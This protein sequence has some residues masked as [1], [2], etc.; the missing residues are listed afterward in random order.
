MFNIIYKLPK[1]VKLSQFLREKAECGA[2][3]EV[4]F[5]GRNYYLPITKQIKKQFHLIERKGKIIP[6]NYKEFRILYDISQE[7]I[8]SIY[9]Q[10]RDVVCFGIEQSL[11]QNLRE[12]FSKLFE[13]FIES[14][15]KE[16]VNL[17]IE[18]KNGKT[19]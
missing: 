4:M 19:N 13:K 5:T 12:G 1:E 8:D 3:L 9:L 15:V 2:Y 14:K 18:N 7:I 16:K 6:T 10:L 11:D 17:R